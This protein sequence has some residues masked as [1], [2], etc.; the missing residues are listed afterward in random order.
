MLK[1]VPYGMLAIGAGLLGGG[2]TIGVW[3]EGAPQYTYVMG[4]VGVLLLVFGL[5]IYLFIEGVAGRR[6][7]Y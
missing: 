4:V 5:T 2:I 7:G 1:W 3:S 6:T